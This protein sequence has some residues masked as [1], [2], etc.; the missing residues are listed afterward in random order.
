MI[1]DQLETANLTMRP[2]LEDD[3]AAVLAYWK[4]DPG[5]ERFNASVPSEFTMNDANV[6]VSEMCAR[7]RKDRPSWAVVHRGLVVGVVSL[8]FEQDYRITV[9]GYGVHG[10]LRGRGLA[11]EAAQTVIDQAFARYAQLQKI[12]AHTDPENTASIR[13]LEKLG[14]LR[15]G[16]LRKNQ[17]V[18]GRLCDEAVF[19]LLRGEW[20]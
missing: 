7:S 18:K 19:G 4:S 11:V 16:T 12:R 5:W 14:F 20:S 9:I 3:A 8:S 13:V 1:P 2:F 6:F 10:D 17:F 15:E